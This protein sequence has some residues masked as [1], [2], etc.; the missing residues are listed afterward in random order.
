MEE[1]PLQAMFIIGLQGI[2]SYFYRSSTQN[3][4]LCQKYI[5]ERSDA[6]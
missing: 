4:R 1:I 6:V 3:C 5:Q 2:F